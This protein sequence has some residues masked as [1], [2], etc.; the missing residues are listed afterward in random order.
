MPNQHVEALRVDANDVVWMA[1]SE[2]FGPACSPCSGGLQ[3]FD[4]TQWIKYDTSNSDMPPLSQVA[5]DLDESGRP[6]VGGT[7]GAI[8]NLD[9]G[10]V[11]PLEVKNSGLTHP[12]IATL[13][14]HPDGKVFTGGG[15]ADPFPYPGDLVVFLTERNGPVRKDILVTIHWRR[16]SDPVLNCTSNVGT[17]STA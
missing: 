5:L 8:A 15:Y 12:S 1:V 14:V 16:P 2:Y 11:Y 9:A 3:S 17:T 10:I 4:G 7:D 6:W 13:L